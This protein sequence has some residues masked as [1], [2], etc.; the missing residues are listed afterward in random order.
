MLFVAPSPGKKQPVTLRCRAQ[1]LLFP[2]L[3]R[4]VHL[5][6]ICQLW[7]MQIA[8]LSLPSVP[9]LSFIFLNV[10]NLNVFSCICLQLNVATF[11]HQ[12]VTLKGMNIFCVLLPD[13]AYSSM[14]NI[15]TAV[16][17]LNKTQIS[18]TSKPPEAR[19][20]NCNCNCRNKYSC[21]MD[22]RCNKSNIINQA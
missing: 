14:S 12:K 1:D 17:N 10:E 5:W 2:Y 16:S 9:I 21:P 15:K 8:W 6:S 18:K 7:K 4:P 11:Q 22:G 20:S 19:K 13:G 3:N